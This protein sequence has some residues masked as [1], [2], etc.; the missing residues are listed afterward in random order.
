MI[1][2]S[3][4]DAISVYRYLAVA[5][6]NYTGTES[7]DNAT[8]IEVLIGKL[9][10]A[11]RISAGGY[12]PDYYDTRAL[13]YVYQFDGKLPAIRLYRKLSALSLQDCKIAVEG[14]IAENGWTKNHL[15][16]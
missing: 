10:A 2:L 7:T 3:G 6:M 9:S 13:K 12:K 11:I 16:E 14:M 4:P 15:P 5:H 1:K 8:E